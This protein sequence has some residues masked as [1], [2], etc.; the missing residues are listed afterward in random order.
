MGAAAA[1]SRNRSA[2]RSASRVVLLFTA[3]A[4]LLGAGA[5][6][7]RA[8]LPRDFFAM[9]SEPGDTAGNG[10]PH[11]IDGN[12]HVVAAF[13]G[14]DREEVHILAQGKNAGE[15]LSATFRAPTGE[16][17][18]P[19]EYRNAESF[20]GL[21]QTTPTL[22][23]RYGNTGCNSFGRFTIKEVTF[24]AKGK[25]ERFWAV[26]EQRC[27]NHQAPAAV[28]EIRFGEPYPRGAPVVEPRSFEWPER[29]ADSVSAPEPITLVGRKAVA[30]ITIVR[31]GG[32]D[33]QDFQI[34]GDDCSGAELRGSRCQILVA[35]AP[36]TTG[37]SEAQLL[38]GESGRHQTVV[39]GS[40]SAG[41]SSGTAATSSKSRPAASTKAARTSR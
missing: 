32:A 26:F 37:R 11:L 6:S 23:A 41:H 40:E 4:A 18:E 24:T 30:H 9:Y 31:L 36:Q 3:C 14:E 39:P 7:A 25:L 19:R 17:L 1:A 10:A 2:R 15:S 12:A 22:E 34:E 20:H 16:H 13:G 5:N 29:A 28:G 33:P 8:S 35:A 21:N 27:Y 38:I